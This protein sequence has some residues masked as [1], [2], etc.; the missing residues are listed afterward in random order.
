MEYLHMNG[1]VH[2]DLKSTNIL[3]TDLERACLTDF[4]LSYI[5]NDSGITGHALSS[6][7][8]PSRASYEAPELLDLDVECIQK[9]Q[10]SDVYAFGMV[11]FEVHKTKFMM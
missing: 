5:S 8:D 4:G 10:A 11:C 2:G 9:T 1:I 7:Y 6:N 3:V